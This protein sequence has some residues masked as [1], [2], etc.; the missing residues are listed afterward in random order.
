MIKRFLRII[1][2]ALIAMALYSLFTQNDL[3]LG[4]FWA[5]THFKSLQIFQ[6]VVERYIAVWLWNPVM[7][8]ILLTPLWVV[9]GIL[10]TIILP[11]GLKKAKP[12]V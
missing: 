1:A 7:I 12:H 9:C 3:T 5:K 2:F 11:F 4:A 8:S 10:G 6:P